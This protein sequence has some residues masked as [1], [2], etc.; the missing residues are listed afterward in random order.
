MRMSQ[1]Q[2]V[3]LLR[4]LAT[5]VNSGVG[6]L[7]AFESL[8]K[9][10]R[11]PEIVSMLQRIEGRLATG[12]ALSAA[13][14]V[15][16]KAFPPITISLIKVGERSGRLHFV[17]ERVARLME[18]RDGT[19][20]K[21]RAALIYP[22]FVLSLCLVLLT[23]APAIVFSDLL[24]LLRELDTGLPWPTKIYLGFSDL[25]LS[26]WFYVFLALSAPTL[27]VAVARSFAR[28]AQRKQ[29]EECLLSMKGL[30]TLF[31]SS[32][33]AIVSQA[34]AI[35]YE[36]GMPV[37]ES[38]KLASQASRFLL[39]REQ[40]E[41]ARRRVVEG[42]DLSQ[43]LATTLIFD[44]QAVSLLAVGEESGVLSDSLRYVA[45]E[46]EKATDYAIEA[47]QKLL[48]PCLMLIVGSIVAFI[49]VATLA[50]TLRVVESL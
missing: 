24:N 25:I 39:L 34:L 26:P 31:L 32:E 9:Q 7:N 14:S 4:S 37:L 44:R 15:E 23:L 2:R 46:S 21:L 41:T 8:S 48:E 35:C 36:S 16:S 49:A 17:L 42:E 5:L 50:P 43:G 27:G 13:L 10:T 1:M 47:F 38:L 6:L 20:R 40:L 28:P 30:G 19:E 22:A 11:D 33:R 18:S 29:L 3:V 45:E 12:Y